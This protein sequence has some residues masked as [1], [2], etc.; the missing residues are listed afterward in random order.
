MY[1]WTLYYHGNQT[2]NPLTHILYRTGSK[3]KNFIHQL[4]SITQGQY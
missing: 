3:S 2:P 4:H 1:F